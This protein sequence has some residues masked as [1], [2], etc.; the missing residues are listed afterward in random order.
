MEF[1]WT[2][3][4]LEILNFLVLLW[5]LQR[6][7]Y[8]PVKRVIEERRAA[9]EKAVADAEAARQA[10]LAL[11]SQYDSRVQEWE[12]EK[13]RARA[14]LEGELAAERARLLQAL[15]A[16][17]EAERAR[18]QALEERRAAELR[19]ELAQQAREDSLRFLARLLER[20][21][22]PALEERVMAAAL[23]DLGQLPEE[24]LQA[25]REAGRGAGGRVTVTSAHPLNGEQRAQCTCAFS[26]VLSAAP[27]VEFR[28]DAA[29]VA[30]VRVAVGP[31]VL[32]AN[33]KD[34]LA[35]F[36]G[37]ERHGT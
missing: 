9:T 7:L 10:A 17:L 19:R 21:A 37:T 22:T 15:N 35:F 3:F 13:A 23:E 26:R 14:E 32:S 18:R 24:T 36:A 6:L 16:S 28:E 11:K 31:W 5:L 25:V 12:A 2:T 8:R 33:L 29:L 4:G 1:S 34:E 30:G 20:L 27:A